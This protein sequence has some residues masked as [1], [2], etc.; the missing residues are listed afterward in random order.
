MN[1][2]R[3][4][5]AER[6]PLLQKAASLEAE[7]VDIE[8]RLSKVEEWSEHGIQYG[9]AFHKLELAGD[10]RKGGTPQSANLS[11]QAALAL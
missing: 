10:L 1:E 9:N 7:L 2:L 5:V 6:V 8:A 11:D 4:L 3:K